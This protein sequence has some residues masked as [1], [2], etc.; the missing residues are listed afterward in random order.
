MS[1]FLKRKSDS[2]KYHSTTIIE[3]TQTLQ[4][5]FSKASDYNT[6]H[7]REKLLDI[8]LADEF[9]KDQLGEI[10][11]AH[12]FVTDYFKTKNMIYHIVQIDRGKNLHLSA[13]F[14]TAL[15]SPLTDAAK[16]IPVPIVGSLIAGAAKKAL[17]VNSDK[18]EF[19]EQQK[20]PPTCHLMMA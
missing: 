18:K 5:I 13:D 9:S 10:K 4:E 16:C 3:V 15:I 2:K 7:K 14:K 19:N 11:D 8:N 6:E 20:N 12:I 17:K 1:V